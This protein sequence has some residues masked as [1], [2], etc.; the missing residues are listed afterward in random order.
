MVENELEQRHSNWLLNFS[1]AFLAAIGISTVVAIMWGFSSGTLT[2]FW[3]QISEGQGAV[4]AQLFT[5]YAAAFAAVFVPLI[6]RGEIKELK[7]QLQSASEEIKSLSEETRNSFRILNDYALQQAGIRA[8]YTID[9]LPNAVTIV[10]S[11][12]TQAASICQEFLDSSGLHGHT[13]A[14]F[15]GRWP[16]GRPFINML[17]ERQVISADHKNLFLKIADSSKYTREQNRVPIN[18][19]ELNLLSSAVRALS[20]AVKGRGE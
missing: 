18:V 11:I 8:K 19:A 4:L 14:L 13:K 15:R 20:E 5:F 9:D 17:H 16:G 1:A 6:F 10:K 3:N 12:Q 7:Q 2:P